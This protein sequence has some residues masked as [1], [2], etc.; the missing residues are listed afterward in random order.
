MVVYV[1]LD[2]LDDDDSDHDLDVSGLEWDESDGTASWEE[3]DDAKSMKYGFTGE[4][5]Q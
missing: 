5:A 1:T 2:A 4:A 3:S